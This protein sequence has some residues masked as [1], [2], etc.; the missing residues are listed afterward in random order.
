MAN[1]T[2]FDC[3]YDTTNYNNSFVFGRTSTLNDLGTLVVSKDLKFE[4][5][6]CF[7]LEAE[8]YLLGNLINDMGWTDVFVDNDGIE[9]L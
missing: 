1:T 6:M 9:V 4:K 8:D 3:Q 2:F 7:N 5:E